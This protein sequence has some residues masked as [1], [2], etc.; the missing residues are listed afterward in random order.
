MLDL[1]RLVTGLRW[2]RRTW[3]SFALLGLFAGVLLTVLFP[4]PPSAVTRVL[5]A[6]ADDQ[7]VERSSLMATDV[8]L[9][10]TSEVARAALEQVHVNERP[11]DFLA[12]YNCV[13]V[14][15]DVLEITVPGTSERDAVSRAQAL[16]D[17]FIANHL[18]RTQDAAD[19]Q[20]K[21]LLDRRARLESTLAM[22]NK[23]IPSTTNPAQLDALNTVRAGLASQILDLE[24]RVEDA[25]M[26]APTVAAGT[27]LVDPPRALP[28]RLIRSGITKVVVSLVLGLGTGLA[29]AAVLCVTG[30]RPVL[31]REIAAEL[32]VSVIAQLPSP[33]R[34]PRRLW[35]RSRHVRERQRLAATLARVVRGADTSISLLEIG[36]PGT[37]APLA[38][39]IAEQVAPER[40][41]VLVADLSRGFLRETPSTSDRAATIVDLADLPLDHPAPVPRP[42]LY[43]GVGS[44]GPGTAWVDLDR[45]GTETLLVVRAGHAT[46][47]GLHTIARQLANSEITAIGVVLVHP[48]PKDRTD[49]TL[50]DGLHTAVRGRNPASGS[51]A[52]P[53]RRHAPSN[54]GLP[55]LEPSA[56]TDE[57]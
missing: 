18:K 46:T 24:K 31:R 45:L 52:L 10:Q 35:R 39:D 48:Y 47:L 11:A 23:T 50:W 44:V 19:A 33:P 4:P 36:C 25:R 8:A 14:T 13:A 1:E 42:E 29:L 43:L 37:A 41:V 7:Q 9:C 32:G 12:T 55:V 34:G 16:S 53:D 22:V 21:P 3:M 38:L 26:G 28:T 5:V 17:V 51:A 57:K 40:P 54:N 30:D 2:R 6:H 15:P 20:V 56:A 49:G 27:R